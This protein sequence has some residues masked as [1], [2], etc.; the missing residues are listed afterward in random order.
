MFQD[1]DPVKVNNRI[2]AMSNDQEGFAIKLVS[3]DA[4]HDFICLQINTTE[5]IY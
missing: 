4:L 2:K 3:D 5:P 1:H